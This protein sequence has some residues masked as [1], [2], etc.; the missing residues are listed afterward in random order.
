M[1]ILLK[2]SVECF[3]EDAFLPDTVENLM[4]VA[5]PVPTLTGITTEEGYMLLRCKIRILIKN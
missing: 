1:G 5:E 3:A 2:P 4:L